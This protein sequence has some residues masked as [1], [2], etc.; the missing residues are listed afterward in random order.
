MKISI[1]KKTETTEEVEIP[2][3]CF[4]RDKSEQNYVAMLDEKTVIKIVHDRFETTIRN[5]NNEAWQSGI[6]E[7]KWGYNKYH[8]CT[9]TEFFTKYYEVIGSISLKPELAL[10]SQLMEGEEDRRAGSW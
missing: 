2:V 1:T 3:P 9:E 7:I 4:F 5:Y 10:V 6:D 8:S